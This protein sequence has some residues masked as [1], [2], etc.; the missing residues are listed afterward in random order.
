M[1]IN[2]KVF[3]RSVIIRRRIKLRRFGFGSGSCFNNVHMGKLSIYIQ[4]R[5][6]RVIGFQAIADDQGR[7]S[8]A[9]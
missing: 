2:F 4:H 9:V 5:R 6:S 8:V 1:D 3:N 7:E